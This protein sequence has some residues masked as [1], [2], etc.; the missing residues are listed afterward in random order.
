MNWTH[1]TMDGTLKTNMIW[2]NTM[3]AN[4]TMIGDCHP[5]IHHEHHFPYPLATILLLLIAVLSLVGNSLVVLVIIKV[6]GDL[7]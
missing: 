2:N 7:S 5:V 4:E 1:R 6:R 3:I